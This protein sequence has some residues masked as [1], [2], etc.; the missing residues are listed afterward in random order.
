MKYL[1]A[2]GWWSCQENEDTRDNLIGDSQIR[3]ITFHDIWRKSI[4]TFTS[5]S[6]IMVIDSA[7]P[8]QPVNIMGEKWI[9]MQKNFGHSTNHIGEHSGYTRAI[10]VSMMYA[11][12][13]DFD[14]WVYI[15]QDAVIYGENFIENTIASSHKGIIYGSGD[16]TPQQI[17]QSLM[18]FKKNEI[19]RFIYNYSK[20][21][22]S[23]RQISPEWKFLFAAN[24]LAIL[25]PNVILKMLATETNNKIFSRLKT[26]ITKFTRLFDQF[27]VLPYGFGRKRPI[28]FSAKN[29]YFQ[30]GSKDEINYFL[31]K[32][33]EY[34]P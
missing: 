11:Y 4:D 1:I 2:S 10:F 14:Y 5:P 24:S 13:N 30:H 15:E 9:Q 12:A 18:V 26:I 3:D 7:S 21:N 27:D 25:M 34:K 16:G 23:D 20:I 22:Y 8:N 19:P 6:E 17:Q 33:K 29:F 32:L 31:E 28:N